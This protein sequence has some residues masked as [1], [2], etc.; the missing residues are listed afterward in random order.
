MV[1][2]ND[3]LY[4]SKRFKSYYSITPTEARKRLN[5]DKR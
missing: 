1:G 3:Q 2:Y 5:K 4:F